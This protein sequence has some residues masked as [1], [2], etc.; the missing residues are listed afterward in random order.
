MR[1]NLHGYADESEWLT[2]KNRID[3]R[4]CALTPPWKIIRYR[5][6]LNLSSLPCAAVEEF[7]TANG[8]ADYALFV[9]GRRPAR[10][11]KIFLQREK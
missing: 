2:R 9:N 5:D 4:L 1:S 6:G 8:P 11:A 7:P 10:F 3:T